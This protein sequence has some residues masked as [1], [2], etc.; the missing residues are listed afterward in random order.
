MAIDWVRELDDTAEADAIVEEPPDVPPGT[1][2]EAPTPPPPQPRWM[3]LVVLAQDPTVQAEGRSLRA[4][5]RV[6]RERLQ[7]GPRGHRFHVV[8]FDATTPMPVPRHELATSPEA[9]DGYFERSDADLHGDPVF[10]AQNVYAIAARTLDA[11]E[12][13]LGRRVPWSYRGHQMFLVPNAFR[14]A[15]AF[16]DP[17]AHAIFF[18]Y[19]D[20]RAGG[21]GYTSLSHD[22]VAH[23]TAHAILD[24]LRAR[25]QEPGLPDQAAFHEHSRT[26]SLSCPRS[27]CGRS[28]SG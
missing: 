26:W 6:P 7:P 1:Q 8:D 18:G 10:R 5:V 25:F 17:D 13:A 27:R 12:N 14:E 23:E 3:E 16:Y 19:F 15:N 24:G 9:Q 11:F 21:W 4:R 20:D 22:I 2:P 28:S